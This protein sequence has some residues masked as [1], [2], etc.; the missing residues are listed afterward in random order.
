M[1]MFNVLILIIVLI[2]MYVSNRFPSFYSPTTV[3]LWPSLG[4]FLCTDSP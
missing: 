2:M 3:L 1:V 4:L